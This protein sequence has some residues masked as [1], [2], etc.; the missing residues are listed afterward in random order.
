MSQ[1]LSIWHYY[2]NYSSRFL[3][4]LKY[5]SLEPT[6]STVLLVQFRNNAST[7]SSV[8][9]GQIRYFV[10]NSV[11]IICQT[12][13]R[14]FSSVSNFNY[15]KENTREQHR[16]AQFQVELLVLRQQFQSS[17]R[18]FNDT[19]TK[20]EAS[21]SNMAHRFPQKKKKVIYPILT[22]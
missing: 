2:L 16:Y 22:M 12:T 18:P 8:Q 21:L 15:N 9:N 11:K 6:N 7:S 10:N 3:Q 4:S 17:I 1:S 5:S 19:E 20:P 13:K 14:S